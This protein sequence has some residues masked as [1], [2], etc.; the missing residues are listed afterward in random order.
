MKTSSLLG[1]A[2]LA[3]GL[4]LFLAAPAHAGLIDGALN[5]ASAA[6]QSNVLGALVNSSLTD[7]SDNNANTA[8]AGALGA[9][10]LLGSIGG[11][12]LPH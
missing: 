12:G 3:V 9:A 2:A 8:A 4:P 11:L 1:A 10:G 6:N 5:N 7:A